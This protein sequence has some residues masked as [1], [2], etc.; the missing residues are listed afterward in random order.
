[1][2]YLNSVALAT[3]LFSSIPNTVWAQAQFSIIEDSDVVVARWSR[4]PAELAAFDASTQVTVYGDGR[5]VVSL[6]Q[7]SPRQ[8]S[9]QTQ[10]SPAELEA[11]MGSLVSS[12]AMEFDSRALAEPLPDTS[13]VDVVSVQSN[14][15]TPGGVVIANDAS[16]A[17]VVRYTADADV[18]R[19][20]INLAEYQPN[21][22]AVQRDVKQKLTV[23]GLQSLAG[24]H[25]E[26]AALEGLATAEQ[27][28]IE[29]LD[30]D[31]LVPVP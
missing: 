25:P 31:S 30:S 17:R 15:N 29:L 20:E 24:V 18:T 2:R 5:V 7:P 6:P 4:T 21:G 27:K 14:A 28:F 13:A 23:S 10:I 3:V 19:F 12:N 9:Y 26:N 1:M 11:L 22:G 16:I 8:G